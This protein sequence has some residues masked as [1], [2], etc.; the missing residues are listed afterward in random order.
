MVLEVAN[1]ICFLQGYLALASP[2]S[3]F[4]AKTTHIASIGDF[5]ADLLISDAMWKRWRGRMPYLIDAE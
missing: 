5:A 1:L 4:N 3:L 2:N